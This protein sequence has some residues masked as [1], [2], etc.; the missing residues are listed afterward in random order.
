MF[1]GVKTEVIFGRVFEAFPPMG[2]GVLALMGCWHLN[3]RCKPNKTLKI[4][5]VAVFVAVKTHVGSSCTAWH[6][7]ARLCMH[8]PGQTL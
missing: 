3:T 4:R 8:C 1:L 2:F 6:A 7:S 5:A